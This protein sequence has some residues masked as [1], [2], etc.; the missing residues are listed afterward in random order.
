MITYDGGFPDKKYPGA[1]RTK[2]S[3]G[4]RISKGRTNSSVPPFEIQR[5]PLMN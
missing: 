1:D 3:F 4:R 5:H 2:T